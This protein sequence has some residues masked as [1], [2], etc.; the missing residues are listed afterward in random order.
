MRTGQPAGMSRRQLIRRSLG[1]GVGPVAAR[2]HRRHHRVPVAEPVERLRRH[3]DPGRLR[4]GQGQSPRSRAPRSRTARPRTS[5]MRAA[6]SSCS[7]RRWASRTAA[8]PTAPAT[9][10]TCARSTSAART[11]AASPTSAPR[12]TGSSAPA[13]ARAMTGWAPRSRSSVRRRAASTASRHVVQNGKLTVDTSKI[14][15]GPLP[16]ALGQP[17]L[18]PAD[19][20]DGLHLMRSSAPAGS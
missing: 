20:A 2:G 9:R 8:A 16:V 4:H 1:A 19:V 5:R 10:P 15:L 11:S 14:T 13:T 18:I 17:G 3:G 6:T 7:T 12:T